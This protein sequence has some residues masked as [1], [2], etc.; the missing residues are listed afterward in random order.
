MKNILIFLCLLFG[1]FIFGQEEKS[2]PEINKSYQYALIEASRQKMI[3]NINEAIILYNECIKANHKCDVAY[4]E[5]GTI[6]SALDDNKKAEM[7][8][9]NA[10]DINP[11]NFWYALAFSE[12]LRIN[13]KLDKSI[14]V[15]RKIKKINSDNE[16]TVNYKIAEIY[17]ERGKYRKVL[18]ILNS[19][20]TEHG[21]SEIVSKMKM[22][23]YKAKQDFQSA[24]RE[25]L[26]LIENVPDFAGYRIILANYYMEIKDTLMAI[27]AYENACELDSSNLIVIS[28][29]SDIYLKKKNYEK[30]IY[31]LNKAFLNDNVDVSNKLQALIMLTRDTSLMTENGKA[32]EKLIVELLNKYPDNIDVKTVAYDYYNGTRNNLYA[33]T[34][35]K[36]IIKKKKDVYI[37]WQQAMYH[38]NVIEN[39]DEMI[40]I[41]EEAL[42]YFPNKAELYLLIGMANYQKKNYDNCYKRLK[43]GYLLV[44][45][46]DELKIR[47]LILL[48]ESSYNLNKKEEAFK[49]YE[50]LIKIEPENDLVKNNY[51]YFLA[52]E[53]IDLEKAKILSHETLRKEPEN[54]TY[55]DTY[56]W[57]L[58]TM[59][60]Y[61]EAKIYIEK[62]LKINNEK[63]PDILFHYAEILYKTGDKSKARM[64]YELAENMGFDKEI[65]KQKL[66][67]LDD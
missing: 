3:G 60:H 2:L 35:I 16:L 6:Y 54:D 63:N 14:E 40:M 17:Y 47:Y 15:L 26:K 30:A 29:L 67:I 58:Y 49:F 46:E 9:K 33:F 23:T 8:L 5:L 59:G 4:Y 12:I 24:E 38:A 50:E 51:S 57:I 31:Y 48:A 13:N 21:I 61:E 7:F 39:Y 62:A 66:K 11:D 25:L 43:E 42:K 22:E 44:N 34:L 41:G 36:Q 45:D 65:I 1:S 64:Y 52:L 27:K 56:G 19:I 18:S 37:I 10:Y 20:E 53:G 55:L 32:V 28:A